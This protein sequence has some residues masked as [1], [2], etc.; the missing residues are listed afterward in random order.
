[1]NRRDRLIATLR[2]AEV[3]RSP[4]SFYELNGLDEDP[5]NDDPFNIYNHP[6]WRPLIDLTKDKTDRIVMRAVPYTSGQDDP[7]DEVTETETF[8]REGSRY[9]IRKVHLADRILTDRKRRDPDI[10]TVWTEEHLLKTIE[11]VEAYLEIPPPSPSGTVDPEPVQGAEQELGDAGIVMIDTP[12]P[13]CL[14]AE[15]FDMADYTIMAMTNQ[16]IFHRLLERVAE[17]LW[18][19]TEAVAATLPGRLWRIV[20]PE[21]ATPPF[22]SPHLFKEYVCRYDQ[23]MIDAIQRHGGYARIHS[24]GNLKDVLGHIISMGVDG[25]D[26]IEPP[27]QGDVELSYV[28]EKCGTQITLF[29]NI[30]LSDV[31]NLSSDKFAEKVKCALEEGPSSNGSGFVL[32]PSACPYG[33]ELSAQALRNY[34]QMVEIIESY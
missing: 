25:L 3:D 13:L 18:A 27:P 33:R 24:H 14:A 19:K 31:Q 8:M 5:S 4:V 16:D 1:M 29:G 34:E 15:L 21:Y 10:N 11:D 2:G 7:V 12:D 20:G 26:P 28:R 30:E 17:R 9:T 22:L 6:S 23:P 32:M